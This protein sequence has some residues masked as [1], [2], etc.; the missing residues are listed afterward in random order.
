MTAT[1][2]TMI[3]QLS[4]R[5]KNRR[6]SAVLARGDFGLF[7]LGSC[8]RTLYVLNILFKLN[9]PWAS[10]YTLKVAGFDGTMMASSH[11]N[12]TSYFKA[13]NSASWLSTAFFITFT[14]FMPLYSRLSDLIGRRPIYFFSLVVFC[15]TSLWCALAQSIESLIL[16]RAFCGLGAGGMIAMGAILTNDLV[17]IYIRGLYQALLS[18]FYGT[19]GALGAA[20]GGFL[21]DTLGWRWTFGVQ[22]PPMLCVLVLAVLATP[23]DLGP[24]LAKKSSSKSTWD[25]V[26]GFDLAGSFL[27]TSTVALLILGSNMGGNVLPWSHPFIIVALVLSAVTGVALIFVERQAAR[28][29]LPLKLLVSSPRGNIVFHNFLTMLGANAVVFNA[30]LYFQAVH[31][32]S[33]STSGFRLAAPCVGVTCC[34]VAS[35]IIMNATGLPKPLII[36]G[37]VVSLAGGIAMAALPHGA[38]IAGVAVAVFFPTTGTGLSLPAAAISNLAFSS[39]EDQAVT[40]TTQ[41][42]WRGLGNVMGIALS[43]LLVQN[44]LPRYLEEY[45]RGEDR[46]EVVCHLKCARDLEV[47]VNVRTR[48][49]TSCANRCTPSLTSIPSIERRSSLRTRNLCALLSFCR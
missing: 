29:V 9:R 6:T 2:R 39:K 40:S 32:D 30:P 21:C 33:P 16:A 24:Q 25:I 36:V 37:S 42:L 27:L 14:A 34:A 19:G 35:G 13:S 38:A 15:S 11:P 28:P 47:I 7:T 46:E 20:L 10:P 22:I 31:L 41:F 26:R 1:P 12:I 5:K 44:A 8:F 17:P 45:V 23:E 43:S 4:L 18:L 48:S 3:I 49:F